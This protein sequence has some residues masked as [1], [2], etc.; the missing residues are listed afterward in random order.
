VP[1]ADAG[2][3]D[4]HVAGPLAALGIYA[5]AMLTLASLR[6]ARARA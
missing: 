1:L 5:A 4:A 2:S 3:A 6:L